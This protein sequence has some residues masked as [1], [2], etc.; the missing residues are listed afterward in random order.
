MFD[1][2]RIRRWRIGHEDHL[3]RLTRDDVLGYYRSRYVPERTI[4]AITGDI[5]V[6]IA[7]EMA[8][9]RYADWA[10][11]PG[12]I[13]RSPEEPVRHDVRSR[14]LRGDVSQAELVL[15]PD[16]NKKFKTKRVDVILTHSW[17]Q[18]IKESQLK[19]RL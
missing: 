12:A 15:S 11:R 4:V 2:H 18:E 5:K 14:T 16:N 6:E 19:N 13:D 8:R 7:L 3:A 9:A 1:R 17:Q 10:P